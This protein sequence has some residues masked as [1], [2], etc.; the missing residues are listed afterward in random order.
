VTQSLRH[1]HGAGRHVAASRP[2]S[3]EPSP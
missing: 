3:P 1:Q 2:V